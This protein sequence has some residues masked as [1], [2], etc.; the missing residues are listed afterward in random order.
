MDDNT[1][2]EFLRA[3]AAAGDKANMWAVG[4]GLGLERIPTENLAVG[5]M[6]MGYLEMA[7]LSGAVRLTPKGGEELAG[8][9][10]AEKAPDLEQLLERIAGAGLELGPAANA[11]LKVDIATLR[12]ALARSRPLNPVL[13]SCL[14][15]ID[16]ALEKAGPPAAKLRAQLAALKP[17]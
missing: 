9:E 14:A 8:A 3:V 15:A 17:A 13:K 7:S 5:L 6:E 10:G 4:E 16:G 12:A 2:L 1:K 11:D